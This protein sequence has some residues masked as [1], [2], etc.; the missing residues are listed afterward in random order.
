MS[1]R[2]HREIERRL[3]RMP[4][5][6]PAAEPPAELLERLRAEIPEDLGER[7]RP[8]AEAEDGDGG[9]GGDRLAPVLAF[10]SRRWLA[11]AAMLVMLVGGGF[12][13]WK[14]MPSL[15][16]LDRQRF[17]GAAAPAAEREETTREEAA[18][19]SPGAAADLDAGRES[20]AAGGSDLEPDVR[21]QEAEASAEEPTAASPG[22]DGR[23]A[24]RREAAPET[25]DAEADAERGAGAP[26]PFEERL[27]EEAFDRVGSP[28]EPAGPPAPPHHAGAAQRLRAEERP[29]AADAAEDT[30]RTPAAPAPPPAAGERREAGQEPVAAGVAAEVPAAAAAAPAGIA[31]AS[32][33]LTVRVLSDEDEADVPGATVELEGEGLRRRRF[34][35]AAG[36]ALFPRLPPGLYRVQASLDG[37]ETVSGQ[38]RV[39]DE[40]LLAELRLPVMTFAEEIVVTGKAPEIS[41]TSSGAASYDARPRRRLGRAKKVPAAAAPEESDVQYAPPP[42]PHD[43]PVPDPAPEGPLRISP[44]KPSEVE[45]LFYDVPERE[46]PVPSI[47]CEVATAVDRLSTFGLDVDTGSYTVLRAWLER[48]AAPPPEAVRVEEVVN[49]QPF[50]DPFA[51]APA[52]P[53][54][55]FRLLADGAPSPFAPGPEHRLLRFRIATPDLAAATRKPVVLTLVVDV[56]GSM[57]GEKLELVKRG[58]RTLLDALRPDDRVA[59]V[60]FSDGARLAAPHGEPAALARAADVLSTEGGTNAEAGLLLGYEVAR[61]AFDPGAANRVMLFSDGVANVG[62]TGPRAML[63]RVAE[64]AADGIELTTVG[65]GMGDFNDEMLETLADRGDGRYAYVDDRREID[66]LFSGELDGTLHTVAEEARAQVLFDPRVVES[67]RQLGYENRAIADHEFRYDSVDA[68]EIGPGHSVTALYEVKLRGTPPP[69]RPLALLELRWRD[70]AAADGTPGRYHEIEQRL[71]PEDLS[72]TWAAASP[73]LRFAA[74]AAELAEQ[75]RRSP[76]ADTSPTTLVTESRRL[77]AAHPQ[78]AELAALA[79]KWSDLAP[80]PHP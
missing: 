72:P 58:L 27:Q 15:T 55:V 63:R 10:P 33:A 23:P 74:V 1:R 21:R 44:P 16:S 60:V 75:L 18:A 59:L 50:T 30:V 20:A 76:H 40:P 52:R 29:P 78:A 9:G 24:P 32:G 2:H 6:L 8:G 49:A 28:A 39:N 57:A 70:P 56:S 61:Q 14:L 22:V 4:A 41:S 79:E 53:G 47:H 46:T 17:D 43:G 69:G 12:L 48:G 34:T 3:R 13:A 19:A 68:G 73:D 36:E 26:R 67:W 65:V 45:D 54:E 80:S 51:A 64:E 7:L 35:N 37:F 11:A 38:V 42:Q 31:E 62:A 71:L 25:R 5:E 66:R 77:A